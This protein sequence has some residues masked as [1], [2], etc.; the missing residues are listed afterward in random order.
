MTTTIQNNN[1][2][3]QYL[4]SQAESRKDWFGFLQQRMTAITLAH[5]I[6]KAHAD[7]MTPSE[8]V[9]YAIDVNES[10]FQKIINNKRQ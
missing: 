9:Q 8:V 3:L 10:I 5:E 1:D 4:I 2:L 7:K 6:A